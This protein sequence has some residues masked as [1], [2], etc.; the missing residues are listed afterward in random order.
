MESTRICT[1]E[2]VLKQTSQRNRLCEGQMKLDQGPGPLFGD[3]ITRLSGFTSNGKKKHVALREMIWKEG[4]ARCY[5]GEL[6]GSLQGSSSLGYEAELGSFWYM[7]QLG[8]HMAFPA[9]YVEDWEAMTQGTLPITPSPLL[10]PHPCAVICK[11]F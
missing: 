5:E 11:G 1:D 8:T 2:N 6:L 3:S 9:Y 7:T 4:C 10:C